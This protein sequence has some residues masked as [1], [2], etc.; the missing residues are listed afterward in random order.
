[1]LHPFQELAL[2]K[3]PIHHQR[4]LPFC[5]VLNPLAI[6]VVSIC[7]IIYSRSMLATFWPIPNIT[8]PIYIFHF[9]FAIKNSVLELPYINISSLILIFAFSFHHV[10]TPF[11]LVDS[12]SFVSHYSDSIFSPCL[13]TSLV[14]SVFIK[15]ETVFSGFRSFFPRSSVNWFINFQ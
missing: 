3:N 13:P 8:I 11:S 2:E 14:S 10:V 5:R 15:L 9:A 12:P 4:S 1:M 6:I 7:V